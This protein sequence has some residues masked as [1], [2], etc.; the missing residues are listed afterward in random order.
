MY[1]SMNEDED[2]GRIRTQACN[3]NLWSP[4]HE[5]VA[6]MASPVIVEIMG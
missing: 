2:R 1:T 6:I 5:F 4:R 3:E